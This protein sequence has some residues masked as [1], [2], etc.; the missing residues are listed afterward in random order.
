M[1]DSL[2]GLTKSLSGLRKREA[3]FVGLAAL[4]PSKILLNFLNEDERPKSNDID[5]VLGWQKPVYDDKQIEKIINRWRL[6]TK[7]IDTISE[8]AEDVKPKGKSKK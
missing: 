7:E 4:I 2:T 5:F 6:Q 8:V 1:P 3:I